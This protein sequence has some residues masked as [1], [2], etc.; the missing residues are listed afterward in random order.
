MDSLQLT[1]TLR[2][3][4]LNDFKKLNEFV[5]QQFNGKSAVDYSYFNEEDLY[6]STDNDINS[7]NE[8]PVDLSETNLEVNECC[9]DE[10]EANEYHMTS[11]KETF[12]GM[13]VYD[14]ID[15]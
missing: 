10:D 4:N 6:D 14:Q 13:R 2:E 7:N 8:I 15:P 11:A 12:K 9:S 5:F 3:N 1:K